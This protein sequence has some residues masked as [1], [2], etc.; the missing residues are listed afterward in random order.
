MAAPTFSS[1]TIISSPYHVGQRD[2]GPGQGPTFLLAHGLA[3]ALSDLNVTVHELEL[4]S[5]SSPSEYQGEIGA[6]FEILRRT[7]EAVKR[8]RST[9]SFPI[10][11]AG[12]CTAAVGV[13]AGLHAA[14]AAKSESG[15]VLFNGELGC[16]WFDAHDDFNTPDSVVSGYFDSM[17]IAMLAGLCWKALLATVE[18]FRPMDLRKKLVHVG[19]RDVTEME[20]ARV[21]DAGFDVV[22]GGQGQ[23]GKGVDFA[24]Q[25]GQVLESK[26]LG[27]T[28]VH[29]DVDC[30]DVSLGKPNQFACPGGL[31]DHDLYACLEGTVSLSEPQSLTVAS[32]DPSVSSD[33]EAAK[34]IAKIGI[35]GVKT[36]VAA[37]VS[38]GML[39]RP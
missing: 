34:P 6:S 19:M 35:K 33:E 12:N 7:S 5:I 28:M 11:L 4:P 38:K 37:L 17:A 36:F 39:S 32:F 24:G 8:A 2:V 21:V 20:R 15:Q 22:W 25:L 31:L 30:L 18:G 3:S 26:R 9:G 10:V 14:S 1:V 13:A 27:P 16:V 23:E 29:L